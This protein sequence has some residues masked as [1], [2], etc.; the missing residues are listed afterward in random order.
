MKDL[1]LKIAMVLGPVFIEH[2]TPVLRE[3]IE[4]YTLRL[5]EKAKVTP[6]EWDDLIVKVMAA[7]IMVDLPE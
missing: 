2:V 7:L 5:W 1:M 3:K 4:E 6:N